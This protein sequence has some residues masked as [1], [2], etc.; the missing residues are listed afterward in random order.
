MT[1]PRIICALKLREGSSLKRR[2]APRRAACCAHDTE[3]M[4]QPQASASIAPGVQAG[5]GLGVTSAKIAPILVGVALLAIVAVLAY[6]AYRFIRRDLDSYTLVKGTQKL[7][8]LQQAITVDS[9]VLPATINGQEYSYSFWLYLADFKADTKHKLVFRRGDASGRNP[10]VFLD[11]NTNK[12]YLGL[13]T[14]QATTDMSLEDIADCG[15]DDDEYLTVQV[16]YIPLQRWVHIAFVVQDQMVS[17]FVDGDLYTVA[18]VADKATDNR[19]ILS[20]THG[21]VQIGVADQSS[22][23]RPVADG[24]IGKFAFFNYGL[25]HADVRRLYAQGPRGSTVL[26]ALGLS[27]YGVRSPV[28]RLSG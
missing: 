19:P 14:N 13:R 3:T 7:Y 28:Y 21:D 16:D 10:V 2:A 9:S 22:D 1:D 23:I 12:L 8:G 17:V 20:P 25:V 24:Y 6:L 4:P 15:T 27:E 5:P 11:K 26:G 18:S